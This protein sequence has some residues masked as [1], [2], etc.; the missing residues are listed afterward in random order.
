MPISYL[1]RLALVSV[2]ICSA[3]CHQGVVAL[4]PA[5][6]GEHQE[7]ELSETRET[8]T[9]SNSARGNTQIEEGWRR[10]TSTFFTFDCPGDWRIDEAREIEGSDAMSVICN[11]NGPDFFNANVIIWSVYI[12]EIEDVP[13]WK[14]NDYQLQDIDSRKF[15]FNLRREPFLIPPSYPIEIDKRSYM[16]YD[17]FKQRMFLVYIS[18]G[19]RN[20]KDLR[21]A[22]KIAKSLRINF[23]DV[24][25]HSAKAKS[26]F[27][28]GWRHEHGLDGKVDRKAAQAAYQRAGKLGSPLAELALA[29][30]NIFG[31]EI[32]QT[33]A[34]EQFAICRKLLNSAV[35]LASSG[36]RE[37]QTLAGICYMREHGVS[38]DLGMA[39]YWFKKASDR[40]CPVAM[41]GLGGL[42]V[43]KDPAGAIRLYRKAI[44]LQSP[45][46]EFWLGVTYFEKPDRESKQRGFD[47]MLSA[48]EKGVEP[49]IANVSHVYFMPE[50]GPETDKYKAYKWYL[51]GAKLGVRRCMYGF[52]HIAWKKKEFIPSLTD[53]ELERA[54]A[55][56]EKEIADCPSAE[57][58]Y[59]TALRSLGEITENKKQSDR[60][61]TTAGQL[62][63]K[64]ARKDSPDAWYEL[65]KLYKTIDKIRP[66]SVEGKIPYCR[67]RAS[68]LGH[69]QAK[70]RHN[71]IEKRIYEKTR[72]HLL[73]VKWDK[74]AARKQES[75]GGFVAGD[76]AY[77]RTPTVEEFLEKHR[78][79]LDDED[80]LFK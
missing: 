77:E 67:K 70:T 43:E 37:A 12:P 3:S 5:Q 80:V 55:D 57:F 79:P 74:A 66:G 48:A 29:S 13:E 40:G 44:D 33:F 76:W 25:Q 59:A 38:R 60:Y 53:K 2:S 64:Y 58:A 49:A 54:F 61:I 34:Q 35:D 32:R 71:E 28:S 69:E 47:L 18:C 11:E 50:E 15:R 4:V 6:Q 10:H 8:S 27:L 42:R 65:M 45:H 41:L 51:N 20:T 39:E 24:Q 1:C 72:A 63:T 26:E 21:I 7:T 23:P 30:G 36:N 31:T 75:V 52:S 19:S 22:T 14:W 56:I 17:E 46:A 78:V 9:T 73:S 68:E 62:M 16:H